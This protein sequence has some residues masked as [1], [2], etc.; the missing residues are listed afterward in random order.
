MTED[1][2][3]TEQVTLQRQQLALDSSRVRTENRFATKHLGAILASAISLAAVVV[4]TA[5]LYVA[6]IQREKELSLQAFKLSNDKEIAALEL[7]RKIKLESVK[8]II[9]QRA[10]LLSDKKFERDLAT[11]A[12]AETIPTDLAQKLLAQLRQSGDQSAAEQKLLARFSTI[13]IPAASYARARNVEVGGGLIKYGADLLHNGPPYAAQ[14]NLVEYDVIV[15]A[16]GEYDLWAQYAAAGSRPV[17]LRVNGVVVNA[18]GLG[19]TTGGWSSENLKWEKQ[20]VF[21]AIEGRNV[22]RLYRQDVFPHIR[23]LEFRPSKQ[24]SKAGG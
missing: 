4:S 1:E 17:E 11:T 10:A 13:Q 8:L 2:F 14:E 18:A 3:R 15:T 19:G 24:L 23:S 20:G 22:L 5:Q 12:I 9:E 21:Q 16:A 6:Y 7:D